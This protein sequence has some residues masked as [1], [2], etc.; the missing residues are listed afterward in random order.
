M[1]HVIVR[2]ES[3]DWA[4][5]PEDKKEKFWEDELNEWP[6]YAEYIGSPSEVLI[7]EYELG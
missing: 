1:R 7:K 3:G 6:D 5:V 4:L 2:S